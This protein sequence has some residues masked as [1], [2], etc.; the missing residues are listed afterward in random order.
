MR[1][2]RGTRGMSDAVVDFYLH[3]KPCAKRSTRL[4]SNDLERFLRTSGGNLK[5]ALMS[6]AE[7]K[8]TRT[9]SCKWVKFSLTENMKSAA[10]A[11]SFFHTARW[12]TRPVQAAHRRETEFQN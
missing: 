4:T 2:I 12:P 11:T 3:A 6:F 5:S 1:C 7:P 10:A 9:L 8:L